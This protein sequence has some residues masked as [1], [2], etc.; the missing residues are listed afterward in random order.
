MPLAFSVCLRP[1][2]SGSP[3]EQRRRLA[4]RHCVAHSALA[5]ACCQAYPPPPATYQCAFSLHRCSYR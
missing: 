5:R 4:S 1:M 3:R 2:R